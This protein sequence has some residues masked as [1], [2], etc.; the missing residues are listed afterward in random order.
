MTQ[1]ITSDKI[2]IIPWDRHATFILECLKLRCQRQ[3]NWNK[4]HSNNSCNQNLRI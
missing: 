1:L 3:E 4:K 2:I